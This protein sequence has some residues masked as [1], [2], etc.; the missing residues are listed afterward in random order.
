[1]RESRSLET[2][3][4]SCVQR[5]KE[6]IWISFYPTKVPGLL[7]YLLGAICAVYGLFSKV[8]VYFQFKL[9]IDI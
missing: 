4:C 9:E 5:L 3:H 6:P 8:I 7:G 2:R 1:M